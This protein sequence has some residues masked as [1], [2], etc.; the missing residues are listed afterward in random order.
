MQKTA[1]LKFYLFKAIVDVEYTRK[2]VYDFEVFYS[3]L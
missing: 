3:L 2:I 1:R